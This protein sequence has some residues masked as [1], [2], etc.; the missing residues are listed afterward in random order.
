MRLV[1][2]WGWWWSSL[3]LV[4]C[5]SENKSRV[6]LIIINR[7]T[8]IPNEQRVLGLD[9]QPGNTNWAAHLSPSPG[10]ISHARLGG[11]ED[12]GCCL[13]SLTSSWMGGQ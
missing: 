13:W 5:L 12:C 10:N 1:L 4:G 9:N 6:A 2:C 7:I 3:G 8:A 11:T